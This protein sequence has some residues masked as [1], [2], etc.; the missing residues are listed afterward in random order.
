MGGEGSSG[1]EEGGEV[2]GGVGRGTQPVTQGPA[3]MCFA[4][5][6]ACNEA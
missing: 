1:G 5:F 4:L 2:K 3:I 6:T